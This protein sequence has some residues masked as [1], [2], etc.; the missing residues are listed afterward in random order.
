LF[1][2]AAQL[3]EFEAI[4]TELVIAKDLDKA[5]DA[6]AHLYQ[7]RRKKVTL[8]RNAISEISEKHSGTVELLNRYLEDE[9]DALITQSLPDEEIVIKI[10]SPEPVAALKIYVDTISFTEVQLEILNLFRKANLTLPIVE[11]EV[12][13][14]NMVYS[15]ISLSTV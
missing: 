13:A 11:L 9:T 1:S 2:N 8:D 6:V 7:P 3:V 14:R 5:M 15:K 12:F 4:I 10:N